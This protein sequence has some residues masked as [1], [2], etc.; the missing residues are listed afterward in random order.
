MY[1]WMI[2]TINWNE[3]NFWFMKSSLKATHRKK[4]GDGRNFRPNYEVK[5]TQNPG[6]LSGWQHHHSSGNL[7]ALRLQSTNAL[8]VHQ[9]WPIALDQSKS[10]RFFHIMEESDDL[11]PVLCICLKQHISSY[12]LL[13]FQMA[14]H[15]SAS[16]CRPISCWHYCVGWGASLFKTP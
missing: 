15:L 3:K 7:L 10:L 1:V 6:G 13:C 14:Q 4:L 5:R 16:F 9:I 2:N 8:N 11:A 12:L